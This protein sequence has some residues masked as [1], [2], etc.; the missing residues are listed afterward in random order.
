MRKITDKFVTGFFVLVFGILWY[1][2]KCIVKPYQY[3]II[4]YDVF[5]NQIN[6]DGIR[7]NFK[8]AKVA[9]NYIIEYKNRFSHYDFSLSTE[10][11]V[12][13]RNKLFAILKKD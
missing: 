11:P 13:K 4:I 3:K 5:G 8:T 6:I 2:T 12:I 10:N 9:H 7:T 1:F